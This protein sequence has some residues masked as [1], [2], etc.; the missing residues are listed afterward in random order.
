MPPAAAT[1]RRRGL[2]ASP[3]P[4][5]PAASPLPAPPTAPPATAPAAVAETR[6]IVVYLT[7]KETKKAGGEPSILSSLGQG[8]ALL[9]G[10]I[11]LLGAVI[12]GVSILSWIG[13]LLLQPLLTAAQ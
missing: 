5:S 12:F 7:P 8:G 3:A 10:S 11:L 2:V 4:A 13:L 1:P 6:K 9:I